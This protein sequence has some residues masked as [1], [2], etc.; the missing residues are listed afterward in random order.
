MI[1]NIFS[2]LFFCS[3]TDKLAAFLELVSLC[4]DS[5][6]AEDASE[7]VSSFFYAYYLASKY[8]T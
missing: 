3:Q 1:I 4:G 2:L 5:K 8:I 6:E 7:G